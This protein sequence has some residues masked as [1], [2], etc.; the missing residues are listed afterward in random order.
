VIIPLDHSNPEPWGPSH[1]NYSVTRPDFSIFIQRRECPDGLHWY[2]QVSANHCITAGFEIQDA[3]VAMD[4]FEQL[5][6]G[7]IKPAIDMF[8]ITT[9]DE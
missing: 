7:A 2:V 4:F 5:A 3:G 9:D 1:L 8:G 6:T